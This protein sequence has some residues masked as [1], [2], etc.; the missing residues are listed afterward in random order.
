MRIEAEA[1]VRALFLVFAW[2]PSQLA[3]ELVSDHDRRWGWRG[4]KP[5]IYVACQVF[6]GCCLGCAPAKVSLGK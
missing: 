6:R 2:C 4:D 5:S 3:A 1:V